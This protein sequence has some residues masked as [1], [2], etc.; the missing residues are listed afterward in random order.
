MLLTEIRARRSPRRWLAA[1]SLGAL[2]LPAFGAGA[3]VTTADVP[4]AVSDRVTATLQQRFPGTTIDSIRRAPLAGLLEVATPDQIVYV[5]E[6]ADL[7]FVGKI[8][9]T[10]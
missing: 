5:T 9:D 10:R 2:S 6:D 3:P 8:F 1:V 7:M 4:N